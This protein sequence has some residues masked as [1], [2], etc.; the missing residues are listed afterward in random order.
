[1]FCRS[2]LFVLALSLCLAMVSAGPATAQFFDNFDSYIAGSQV[3]GNNGWQGWAGSA[4]AGALVSNAQSNSA[5]NSI[6]INGGSDLVNELGNPTSGN[7]VLTA[8]QYIPTGFMGLGSPAGSYF[9]V[10]NTYVNGGTGTNWSTELRFLT[11]GNIIDN[12]GAPTNQVVGTWIPDQWVEL[13][14]EIDL[15]NDTLN[16]YYNGVLLGPANQPWANRP[17]SGAGGASAIGAIDLFANGSSS[18]FYDN[19]RLAQVPEP[20]AG[21]ISLFGLLAAG[22]LRRR[23]SVGHQ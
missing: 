17:G 8:D 1:M 19:V 21:L 16:Q 13:R 5:P 23:K 22:C 9:I 2:N 15:D 10:L 4:A 18:V 6:D 20:T 14:M 12:Y 7:W 3:I 11:N